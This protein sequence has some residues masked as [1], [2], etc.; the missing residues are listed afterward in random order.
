M[1]LSGIELVTGVVASGTLFNADFAA[2]FGDSLGWVRLRVDSLS[3]AS[4][5]A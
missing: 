2:S 1:F 4:S 5:F 3:E